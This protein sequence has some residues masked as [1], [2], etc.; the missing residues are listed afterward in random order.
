MCC[1]RLRDAHAYRELR[2]VSRGRYAESERRRRPQT[3]SCRDLDTSWVG[4]RRARAL[5]ERTAD[6]IMAVDERLARL[7]ENGSNR[8]LRAER[9]DHERQSG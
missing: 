3:R 4:T 8:V 6:D 5:R 7:E 1:T 9:P 2:S